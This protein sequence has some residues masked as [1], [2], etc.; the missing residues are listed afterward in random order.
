MKRI[1]LRFSR[2][3]DPETT[4]YRVYRQANGPVTEQSPLLMVIQQPAEPRSMKVEGEVLT[5]IGPGRYQTRYQHWLSDTPDALYIDGAPASVAY[6]CDPVKGI[7]YFTRAIEPHRVVT[8]DYT[9][10]G[11]EVLDDDGEQ[12]GVTF[13]GPYAYDQSVPVAPPNVK[14]MKDPDADQVILTWDLPVSQGTTFHYRIQAVDG[15]GRTSRFS[16]EASA[17]L[18]NNLDDVPYLVERSY[19]GGQTWLQVSRLNRAMYHESCT[20]MAPPERLQGAA[21]AAVPAA[22]L[23][24]VNITFTWNVPDGEVNSPLYRVKAVNKGQVPGEASSPAGPVAVPAVLQ[25]IVIRRKAWDGTYPTFDG[26]DA[27][28][29]ATL[30][31]TTTTYTDPAVPDQSH[32]AYA[33]Y[34]V[35]QGKASPPVEIQ[36]LIG[37]A[38]AAD[39]GIV[40]HIE[41]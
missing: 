31:G 39:P 32:W 12:E 13:Y 30:S 37:D 38:T 17:T 6:R 2:N 9:F 8:A 23:P 4:A 19:D 20:G 34:A 36:V 27:E 25:S 18:A 35:S 24:A 7:I 3:Q 29:I 26:P 10:D 41:A 15:A 33:I 11:I 16:G 5:R 21:V 14:L 40:T 28:T 22:G 1:W